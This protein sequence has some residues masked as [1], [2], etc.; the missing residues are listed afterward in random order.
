MLRTL[1]FWLFVFLVGCAGSFWLASSAGFSHLGLSF[2]GEKSEEVDEAPTAP[3][4]L[5]ILN[6]TDES[7]LARQFSLLVVSHGCLVEGVGNAAGPWPE[8]VLVNHRLEPA[9]ALELSRRLAD[10]PVIRQWD[11]RCSE[12]AVLILGNDFAR[13]KSLLD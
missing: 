3:V 13:I 11:E 5:R 2:T 7:G 10:V 8:S 1:N 12:D 4:H 6:G 9:A